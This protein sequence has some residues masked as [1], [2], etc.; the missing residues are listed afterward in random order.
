MCRFIAKRA[1]GNLD[2]LKLS[3]ELENEGVELSNEKIMTVV[4][5][6]K[7]VLFKVLKMGSQSIENQTALLQ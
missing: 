2:V 3:I 6:M 5:A 1:Q 7:A 4:H